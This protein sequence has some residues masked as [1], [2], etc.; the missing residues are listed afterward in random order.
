MDAS[1]RAA[2][3]QCPICAGADQHEHGCKLEGKHVYADD[4]GVVVNWP[5]TFRLNGIPRILTAM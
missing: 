4:L 5:A 3:R 2:S 1:L